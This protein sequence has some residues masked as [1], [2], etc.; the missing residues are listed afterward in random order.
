M[1]TAS[2]AV[3][4]AR[5]VEASVPCVL[6]AG[7]GASVGQFSHWPHPGGGVSSSGMS[8]TAAR[9]PAVGAGAGGTIVTVVATAVAAATA[10]ASCCD[11]V[12][13]AMPRGGSPVTAALPAAHGPIDERRLVGT[14]ASD[15][16]ALAGARAGTAGATLRTKKHKTELQ[17]PEIRDSWGECCLPQTGEAPLPLSRGFGRRRRGARRR[18]RSARRHLCGARGLLG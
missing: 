14:D 16:S 1:T 15:L 8:T 3:K 4:A 13:T 5:D 11:P 18:R 17:P 9:P 12:A 6:A 7:S 2:G 10:A